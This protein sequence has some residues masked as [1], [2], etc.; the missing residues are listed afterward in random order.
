MAHIRA[1]L[2]GAEKVHQQNRGADE[3]TTRE[4]FE[5]LF[6]R[7]RHGCRDRRGRRLTVRGRESSDPALL[8]RYRLY[9]RLK[10]ALALPVGRGRSAT[11][12]TA[13]VDERGKH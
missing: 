2:A 9:T 6:E 1:L 12:L 10:V 13:K 4:R 3:Q 7:S 8:R 11:L 5:R